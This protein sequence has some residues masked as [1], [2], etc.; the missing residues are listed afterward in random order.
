M[1]WDVP[2]ITKLVRTRVGGGSGGRRLYVGLAVLAL[3]ALGSGCGEHDEAVGAAP[4]A[5][6]GVPLPFH[7]AAT[8]VT[9]FGEIPWPSDLY[10]NDGAVVAVPGLERIAANSK[11]LMAGLAALDGFGRS[12]GALFFLDTAVD[13]QRLPR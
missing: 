9:P 13:A 2:V 8:G 4:A 7:P 3:I 6:A 12:T 5:V 10:R 1:A 11:N